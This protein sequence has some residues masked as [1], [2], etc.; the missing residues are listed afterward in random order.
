M[1]TDE[2]W[3]RK[4]M[5]YLHDPPCKALDIARHEEIAASFIHSELPDEKGID[6]RVK[7]ADSLDAAIERFPFPKRVAASSFEGTVNHTFRH[8]FIDDDDNWLNLS[9][10]SNAVYEEI[11]HDA[12]DTIQGDTRQKFFLYWRRWREVCSQKKPELAYFPADTRLPDHTIWTHL[13]ITA[14]LEG[15]HNTASGMIEPAFLIF[16]AGPVQSFVAA[17]RSTRD[18]WS[19][20]YMLSW[21]MG[22]AI[23]AITDECGPDSIVFPALRGNGI[24]DILNKEDFCDTIWVSSKD[25][26]KETLWQCLYGHRDDAAEVLTNPTL[27]NRF[28]ALVPAWRAK[29]L[30]EKAEKAFRDELERIS[31]HCL[32]RF[33]KLAKEKDILFED[34]WIS[35]WRSQVSLHS[36]ITWQVFPVDT[37]IDVILKKAELLPEQSQLDIIKQM[38]KFAQEKMPVE[39][40]N[41]R[42]Y[43]DSSKTHLKSWGIAWALNYAQAEYRLAARRNTRDFE[44]FKTDK[45]Q[46]GTPKDALTGMEEVIGSEKLWEKML[47]PKGQLKDDVNWFFNNNEKSYGAISII[48]RLWCSG[49]DSYI[50]YHL[51]ISKKAFQKA[52]RFDSVQEVAKLNKHGRKNGESNSPYVAVIALDGDSM[53]KW[54]SGEKAPILKHLLA[55]KAVEYFSKYGYDGI[56]RALTPSWHLQFSEAL[57]NFSNYIAEPVV[58]HYDGQLIYAGG[59]DVMAMLPADRALECASA[60]R[61]LFRGDGSF[62]ESSVPEYS[63]LQMATTQ[64][65]FVATEHG[66]LLVPG[67]CADVSCGIAVAHYKYPLQSIVAEARNAEARAKK[68]Y[69]RAAMAVSLLKHS[70]EIVHW[71]AKWTSGALKLYNKYTALRELETDAAGARFPYALAALLDGYGFE[72]GVFMDGFTPKE[73]FL[74][75]FEHVLRQQMKD[76]PE[77]DKNPLTRNDKKTLRELAVAYLD[78]LLLEASSR[79]DALADFGKLFLV[80]AFL[81]RNRK[82]W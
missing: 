45:E 63:C 9:L 20:S 32:E 24:F 35:R 69:G 72:D 61:G 19:G 21:L 82:E 1:K 30:A 70:G 5:A 29:E 46:E 62:L 68:H 17:A 81:E 48:K 54:L 41:E 16:Q 65:G 51:G 7:E 40:R 42:F 34:K 2:Y 64:P 27:P 59:D 71:G 56:R 79:K 33:I 75:E 25:G 44:A 31:E 28:F 10:D 22:K 78:N 8:P 6:E 36:E 76:V 77:E 12:I 66:M 47:A 39:E 14:A 58:R 3:K 60:L 13:D 43:T 67:C 73:V 4:L 26:K 50:L 37:D 74:S 57:S 23:K 55:G 52:L 49:E 15:C 11:I 53:G 18:L 38:L 80:A